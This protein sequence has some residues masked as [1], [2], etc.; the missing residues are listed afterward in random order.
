M[1][2]A[3]RRARSDEASLLQNI[4]VGI[5]G[6]A[7]QRQNCFWFENADFA[8]HISATVQNFAWQW[9]VVWRS[10]AGRGGDVAI[11]E[12]QTIIAAH[13]GGLARES[14]FVKRGKKKITGSVAGEYAAGAISSV[15][16][17]CKPDDQ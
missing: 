13:R 1:R 10:T 2:E 4:Q 16:R 9:F 5:P 8:L 17:G 7:T 12:P 3:V 14:S 6:D 15:C 11:N